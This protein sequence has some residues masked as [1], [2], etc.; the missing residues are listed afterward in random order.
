M[1]RVFSPL[2]IL[3]T[4]LP[5]FYGC[6]PRRTDKQEPAAAAGTM[7][8]ALSAEGSAALTLGAS[9][10]AGNGWLIQPVT[11]DR[12]GALGV[13]G[14]RA[15]LCLIR[16]DR[17]QTL[18]VA[19]DETSAALRND[20]R[21]TGCVAVTP[22]MIL[23]DG[24][25]SPARLKGGRINTGPLGSAES[26]TG[27]R[28]LAGLG[29]TAHA[30]YSPQGLG[31]PEA[32]DALKSG[33]LDAVVWMAGEAP[34]TAGLARRYP[35]LPLPAGGS[36]FFRA[37]P[38]LCPLT[39]RTYINPR[40]PDVPTVASA[41]IPWIL[42]CRKEIDPMTA[43]RIS[44]GVIRMQPETGY[45]PLLYPVDGNNAGRASLI[46]LHPGSARYFTLLNQTLE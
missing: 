25:S 41:G 11:T 27:I 20:C 16:A 44:R 23:T 2:L 6:A 39:L 1:K 35:P 19:G 43:Y 30:G 34:L 5:P 32:F 9:L 15:D 38:W 7:I 22:V 31:Y 46:P 37:N 36:S 28:I 13:A 17:L 4:L 3:L 21:S 12:D 24:A 45:G 14:G 33:K 10:A 42:L 26:A 40:L 29:L 18:L 8:L